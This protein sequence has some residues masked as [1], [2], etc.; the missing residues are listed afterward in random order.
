M[1]KQTHSEVKLVV[2]GQRQLLH[3]FIDGQVRTHYPISTAKRGFG[4]RKGS[5]KTPRG[6]HRIQAKIGANQTI[7]SVFVARRPSGEIYQPVLAVHDPNRDWILSRIL[8]LSGCELGRN[9]LGHVDTMQRYIYL[10]GSPEE[11]DFSQPSSHG[12]IRMRNPHIIELFDLVSIGTIVDIYE[13][14]LF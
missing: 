11:A 4:E 7:N 9:R 6:Q 13:D 8:W 1:V 5:E 3:V 2:E 10:H 14:K 12:C